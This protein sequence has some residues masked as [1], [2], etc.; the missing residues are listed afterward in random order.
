MHRWI[1]HLY[2]T[3]QVVRNDAALRKK[4]T[5]GGLRIVT[6]MNVKDIVEL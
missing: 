1:M 3:V 6:R 5:C 2:K 4:L